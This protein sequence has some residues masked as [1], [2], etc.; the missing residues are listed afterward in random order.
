MA[1]TDPPT[2]KLKRSVLHRIITTKLEA[3]RRGDFY[4]RNHLG[5]ECY[6]PIVAEAKSFLDSQQPQSQTQQPFGHRLCKRH[7]SQDLS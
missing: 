2:I 7:G 1:R 3:L 6:D 4:V 5:P